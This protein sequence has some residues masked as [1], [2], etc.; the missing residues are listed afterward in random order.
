[1][2]S[3]ACI[4]SDIKAPVRGATTSEGRP[5]L[6]WSG[7]ASGPFRVEIESRVPEGPTLV[8]LD[9]LATSLSV[10]LPGALTDSRAAVRVRVTSGCDV[11]DGKGLLE[12]GATF[13]I[14]TSPLCPAPV[15]VSLTADGKGLEWP[16]TPGAVLY[17]VSLRQEDGDPL[18]QGQTIRPRFALPAAAR[19]IVAVV[20]PY[21]E[22][23]FGPRGL[24]IIAAPER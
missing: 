13:W 9:L 6:H 22:T 2:P 8:R 4:Q 21:C 10:R 5:E 15:E 12:T 17:D 24:A 23:G 20:R 16:A 1:M 11:D 7:S 3:G 18:A 14:D 19:T